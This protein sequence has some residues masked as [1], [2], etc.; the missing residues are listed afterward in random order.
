[1]KGAVCK[2]KS[3]LVLNITLASGIRKSLFCNQGKGSEKVR[4][5]KL[6]DNSRAMTKFYCTSRLR[7]QQQLICRAGENISSKKSINFYSWNSY[8]DRQ[9]QKDR[10]FFGKQ[11]IEARNQDTC[12][13]KREPENPTKTC[14]EFGLLIS[15]CKAKF[16][17]ITEK[18]SD[19]NESKIQLKC[20]WIAS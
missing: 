5:Q 12:K 15:T 14:K 9:E 3:A 10:Q 7:V 4:S 11:N 19:E 16:R 6:R 13:P 20:L 18:A 17:A 2:E 1:M 8:Q